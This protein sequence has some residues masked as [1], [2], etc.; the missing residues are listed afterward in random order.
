MYEELVLLDHMYVFLG[1][2]AFLSFEQY[3]FAVRQG[4]KLK[5]YNARISAHRREALNRD[6]RTGASPTL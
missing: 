5:K 1:G 2:K 6:S 3:L 4:K